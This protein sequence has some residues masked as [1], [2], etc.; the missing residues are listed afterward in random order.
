MK[1]VL[2]LL[3][4]L[5]VMT[6]AACTQKPSDYSGQYPDNVREILVNKCATAGCHNAISNQGAG[7]LRLDTWN[8]LF[9]GAANGSV[10]IPYSVGNSSLLYFINTDANQGPVLEP[11]MPLNNAP[12]SASE[13][14][15]IKNWIANGSPD[16]TGAIPYGSDAQGRQKIYLTQQGCDL[17]AVIDAAT[18]N[19]MRYIEVGMTPNIEVPHCVRF[20]SDGRYAYVSFTKGEYLQKIDVNTDAIVANIYLGV[21]GWNLFKISPDDKKILVCDFDGGMIKYLDLETQ[22]VQRTFYD[23]INP[24][25][26]ESNPTFDTFFVTS[27]FG[28]IVYQITFKALPTVIT[29]DG[30]EPTNA[31]TSYNP[32]EII[33]SPDHSKYFLTCQN[34]NEVRVMDAHTNQLLKV[35]PVGAFPQ[36]FA[37]A[38]NQP[39]LFVSCEE[40]VTAAYPKF[41][42]TVYVINYNTL[43]VVTSI[44]GPFYQIHGITVDE[45][46][47]QLLIASRN[48]LTTGPAPHHTSE[49]GGRNGYYNLYDMNTFKSVNGK[50]Y[51]ATV[52]PY[53]AD[54]RFKGAA[55]VR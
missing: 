44:E 40:D 45:Q 47:N 11:Q 36:E 10:I 21:G 41:R 19:I 55:P 43:E 15:I 49:C 6:T 48:L 25:G 29:I 24:H 30:K 38:H 4:V 31:N 5:L 12:L 13:Y 50:R 1:R 42:G 18:G 46:R 9:S 8:A 22:T 16:K 23:F 39:Y 20:T 37:L 52:D 2:R 26:V 53:S 28:N 7:G 3:L 54:V 17:I 33:M 27:Q 14:A 34:S 51:E 35:I 32:H